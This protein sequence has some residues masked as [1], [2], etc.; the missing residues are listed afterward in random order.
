[1]KTAFVFS[2]CGALGAFQ[3]GIAK[4]L[5]DSHGIVPDAVY[6]VSSGALNSIAYS[7]L[8]ADGNVEFWSQL[9]KLSDAFQRNL[10]GLI[11][12]SDGVM[13]HGKKMQLW[14]Q[15]ALEGKPANVYAMTYV[16]ST[17]TG[18]LEQRVF[19]GPD[20]SQL[21]FD[22]GMAACAIPAMC[23]SWKG[24]SDAG[25]RV[26]APLKDAIADGA[27]RIFVIS[28]RVIGRLETRKMFWP[29]VAAAGYYAIDAALTEILSRD[30]EAAHT[31]NQSARA[32]GFNSAF[33]EVDIQIVQPDTDIGGPLDFEKCR[34]FVQMGLAKAKSLT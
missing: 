14:M 10:W 8:G 9:T 5:K 30:L 13:Q 12:G 2:G 4:G 15:R 33:R 18:E 11:C 3:A 22:T 7:F 26:L 21:A 24:Y 31:K 28:G 20:C 29:H 27:E 1:M 16:M 6:G 17:T 34:D 25:L 23:E 32:L 19:L